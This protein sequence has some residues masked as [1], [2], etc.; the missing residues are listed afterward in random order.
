MARIPVALQMYT[1]RDVASEDFVGTL[2]KVAEIGYEGV[3]LAGAPEMSASELKKLMDDLGL[4]MAGAHVGKDDLTVNLKATADY[5]QELGCKYLVTSG[6]VQG[7]QKTEDGW[8][9]GAKVFEEVGQNCKELGMAF[10]YHNH[11]FEFVQF[12]G[13]YALDI[14]YEESDPELVKAEVD[15]YW[16]QHGN[17]DPTAFMKRHGARAPLIHVKDMDDSEDRTFTEVGTGIIDF[18]AAFEVCEATA[19][20]WYIVEQDRCNMPSVESAKVSFQGM[21]K[22]GKV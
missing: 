19:A 20:E 6:L 16:V 13:K 18:P 9:E 14:L 4:K 10:A 7:D 21:Q 22:M 17:E 1:V 2:K 11:S 5:Y 8:K 15:L 3:E 12:G